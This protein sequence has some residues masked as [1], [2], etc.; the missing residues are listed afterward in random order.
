[1]RIGFLGL[2]K[3]G[4]PM[5][6]RLLAA[7]HEFT[8]WN[9]T[10]E[11]TELAAERRRAGRGDTGRCCPRQRRRDDH[12]VRRRGARGCAFW[13]QG[14]AG[15]WAAGRAA[16][17]RNAHFLEHHQRDALGTP[18]GGACA[19]RAGV[20]GGSGVRPAQRSRGRQVVDR[21]GRRRGCGGQG[22][23]VARA[24][25]ARHLGGGKG[26]EAGPRAQAGRQLSHQRHDSF[27]GR[28]VCVCRSR[29]ASI[30]KSFWRR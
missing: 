22:Q 14:S 16:S 29:R 2:G 24:A 3:M 23:A 30:R 4:V 26:T 8:V 12:A 1:M 6:K 19:A 27:A 9:R 7:R 17:R 20:R 13:A 15:E 10:H 25:V 5:A 21:D 28:V 18:D 11:R